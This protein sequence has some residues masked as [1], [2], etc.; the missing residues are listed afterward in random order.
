[1]KKERKIILVAVAVAALV[2]VGCWAGKDYFSRS[3]IHQYILYDDIYVR[4]SNLNT[5]Y[6]DLYGKISKRV[7]FTSEGNDKIE[8]ENIC[9]ANGDTSYNS[10]IHTP[11]GGPTIMTEHPHFAKINVYSNKDF[12][13]AHP[14][15]V[16]LNDVM[17]II[18]R[19]PQEYIKSGYTAD[20]TLYFD[21]VKRLS[22]LGEEDLKMNTQNLFLTF[23]K[24]PDVISTHT[25][26][27]ECINAIGERFTT[28]YNY[29]FS[30]KQGQV[31]P[32]T[33]IIWE[34]Y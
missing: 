19:S 20:S 11:S 9:K 16:A 4:R 29:D 34:R 3:Y 24:D 26:T 18:Y 27:F 2:M 22:E 12:D 23:I 8:Y 13:T 32:D 6:I 17:N 25:L 31:E 10:Y 30:L 1:M 33:T 5:K 21:T 28:T 14:A 7:D 15:G